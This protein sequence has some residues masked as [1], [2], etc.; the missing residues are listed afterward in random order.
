MAN[1]ITIKKEKDEYTPGKFGQ[2]SNKGF[3][4]AAQKLNKNG[5]LLWLYLC[6][7]KDGYTI[8]VLRPT[9]VSNELG[10]TI[11]V[12][13]SMT[14]PS[15]GYGELEEKGFIKDGVFYAEGVPKEN[16]SGAKESQESIVNLGVNKKDEFKF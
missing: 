10:V 9:T 6:N 2:F 8:E 4:L 13:K 7:N 3:A 5:L 12:A 1:K 14:S 15:K 16:E 11:D